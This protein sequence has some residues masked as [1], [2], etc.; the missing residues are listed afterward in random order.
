MHAWLGY[1]KRLG[2]SRIHVQLSVEI[3][4]AVSQEMF[5]A[6]KR[7]MFVYVGRSMSHWQRS[8]CPHHRDIRALKQRMCAKGGVVRLTDPRCDLRVSPQ[9]AQLHCSSLF[10][11]PRRLRVGR[12][13]P[14]CD[15]H[16]TVPRVQDII[17]RVR[18]LVMQ[19]HGGQK[20]Y[21]INSCETPGPVTFWELIL[22]G[23][24]GR[25]SSTELIRQRRRAR[26]E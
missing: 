7:P 19:Y 10:S 6:S 18:T 25:Q 4:S 22:E 21:R 5:R 23:P 8:C 3:K 20:N 17:I 26:I 13:P 2:L 11:M 24:L 14:R 16:L 1:C 9:R 15:G 12:G